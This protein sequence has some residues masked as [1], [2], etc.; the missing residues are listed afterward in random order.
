MGEE[1]C[2]LV[3]EKESS[4][5]SLFQEGTEKRLV[6][7]MEKEQQN[8]S[9]TTQR[10]DELSAGCV[11]DRH[12]LEELSA[13]F[14]SST[15]DVRTQLAM[16]VKERMAADEK[17]GSEVQLRMTAELK[18][19]ESFLHQHCE[20]QTFEMQSLKES[21]TAAEEHTHEIVSAQRQTLLSKIEEQASVFRQDL[22]EEIH[23]RSKCITNLTDQVGMHKQDTFDAL[24]QEGTER[25][26]EDHSLQVSLNELREKADL[27][28]T[29]MDDMTK[30]V[31]DAIEMHTHDI[32][33]DDIIDA[34]NM[35]KCGSV[36]S[37]RRGPQF[38]QAGPLRMAPPTTKPQFAQQRQPSSGVQASQQSNPTSP[39]A[40]TLPFATR[41][42]S[43][44]AAIR[45]ATGSQLL[46][47]QPLSETPSTLSGTSL[48]R[49]TETHSVRAV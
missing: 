26:S 38:A 13:L 5:R 4:A 32:R 39:V 36:S 37:D 46:I 2:R 14:A 21:L 33:V 12:R 9:G 43:P 15:V 11:Q 3:I 31:W 23:L 42:S 20:Q 22:D 16:E 27:F 6:V 8:V 10:L 19:L 40:K 30:R 35:S 44:S 24:T 1:R 18:A 28:K 17:F 45:T 34:D 41:V 48:D 25:E 47:S 49:R 29:E 7:L